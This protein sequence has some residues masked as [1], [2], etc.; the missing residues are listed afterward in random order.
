MCRIR[1]VVFFI[2]STRPPNPMLARLQVLVGEWRVEGSVGGQALP[3]ARSSCAWIEDGAFLV[4]RSYPD[5]AVS[6]EDL[7]AEF[8]ASSPLPVIALIGL[9]DTAE[10]FTTLYADARGIHRVYQ[11]TLEG[12]DWR[13]WRDAPGFGQ[14]FIATFDESGDVITGAWELC[15]DGETWEPD[16]DMTYTRIAS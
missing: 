15:R 16:F 14:R 11:M 8:L 9:D 12:R 6:T 13:M 5:P 10:R 3:P 1:L 7:P 2:V 4:Q